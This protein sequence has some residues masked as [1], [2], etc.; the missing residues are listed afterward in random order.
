MAFE[1]VGAVPAS[2]VPE[3][4]R[5]SQWVRLADRAITDHLKGLVTV[6]K[7]DAE[8]DVVRLRHN[9]PHQLHKRNFTS[10]PIVVRGDGGEIRVFLELVEHTPKPRGSRDNST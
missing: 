6:V 4:G 9:L 8:E 5:N 7:M 1:V 10:K 3:G 2:E